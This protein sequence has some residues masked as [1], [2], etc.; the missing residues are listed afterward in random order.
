MS[1]VIITLKSS[2]LQR[3]VDLELPGEV[4]TQDLLPA[5]THA[6]QLPSADSTGR[7]IAY[8]LVHEA[9]QRPLRE[10]QTLLGAGVITG[11][12]LS[13]V[14][15][16]PRVGVVGGAA[17]GGRPGASALLRSSLPGV[18]IALDNYGRA[19]L[20]IGRYDARTGQSPDIDLSEEPE[21]NT[22]SRSHALLRKQG[23]QWILVPLSAKNPTRVGRTKLAP[24]QSW[25]LKSGDV[26]ALGGVKL[27][28]EA[29][30]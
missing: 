30:H 12:V 26:I 21:G 16:V 20:T 15:S 5:L 23:D 22:V 11:D 13:L 2:L 14:S 27:V 8:Q 19:E 24:S 28:F 6:L 3:P 1:S 4:A 10:A 18:V 7:S 9:R 25:P 17:G 29:G